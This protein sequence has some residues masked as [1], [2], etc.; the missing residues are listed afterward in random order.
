[1]SIEKASWRGGFVTEALA[2][3][4]RYLVEEEKVATI[5]VWCASDNVGSQRAMEKSGMVKVGG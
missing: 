5:T 2:A 4:P 1:M 3:V